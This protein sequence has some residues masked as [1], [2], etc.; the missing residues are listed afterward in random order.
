MDLV[1]ALGSYI[2]NI[3]WAGC[4]NEVLDEVGVSEVK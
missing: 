1:A 2:P 3:W 4:W